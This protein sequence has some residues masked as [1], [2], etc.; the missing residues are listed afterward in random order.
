[1]P[2]LFADVFISQVQA[3]AVYVLG[4]V[5]RLALASAVANRLPTL[6][7]RSQS[8][9]TFPQC[10]P[11]VF[12]TEVPVTNWE[13]DC[14]SFQQHE[15]QEVTEKV[16]LCSESEVQTKWKVMRELLVATFP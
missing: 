10:F 9:S 6:W 14:L 7:A 16:W 2:F 12:W 5:Q 3:A 4:V 15:G 1:M 11:F 13:S 8:F